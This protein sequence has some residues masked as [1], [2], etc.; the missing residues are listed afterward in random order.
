MTKANST[1]ISLETANLLKDC[2]VESEY[3]Y[4]LHKDGKKCWDIVN[5][6]SLGP[7]EWIDFYPAYSWKEILWEHAAKFFFNEKSQ[8]EVILH[9]L[10][11]QMYDQADNIFKENCIFI[12]QNSND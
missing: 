9:F 6:E 11:M 7:N 1:H 5:I 8:T 4:I 2:G 12:P 10:R 3:W